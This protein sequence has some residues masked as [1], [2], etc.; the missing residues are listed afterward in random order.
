MFKWAPTVATKTTNSWESCAWNIT[1]MNG[2]KTSMKNPFTGSLV[3]CFVL[4]DIH[5]NRQ[6]TK[7]YLK[8]TNAS[9]KRSFCSGDCKTNLQIVICYKETLWNVYRN[10]R[11]SHG[12]ISRQVDHLRPQ[13]RKIW[14]IYTK[15]DGRPQ[16]HGKLVCKAL[17]GPDRNIMTL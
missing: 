14:H 2:V 17:C 11:P 9:K 5:L 13:E 15:R 12:G 10:V 3:N 16:R 7:W 6:T 1:R 4:C 8:W